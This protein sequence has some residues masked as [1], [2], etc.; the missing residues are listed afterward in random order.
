[1]YAKEEL[2]K[3]EFAIRVKYKMKYGHKSLIQQ[4]KV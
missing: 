4:A 2:E 1:M 3:Y